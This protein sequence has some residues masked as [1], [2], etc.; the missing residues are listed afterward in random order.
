MEAQ[1]GEWL[2]QGHTAGEQQGQSLLQVCT[3]LGQ[4][5]VRLMRRPLRTP[6][7]GQEWHLAPWKAETDLPC[8]PV[9]PQARCMVG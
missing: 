4:P 5:P 3:G 1:T 6:P 2:A 8:P 9:C 7:L